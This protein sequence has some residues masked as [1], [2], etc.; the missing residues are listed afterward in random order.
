MKQESTLPTGEDIRDIT[1]L[2]ALKTH[3]TASGLRINVNDLDGLAKQ[4]GSSGTYLYR[5]L[6]ND[7]RTKSEKPLRDLEAQIM[8]LLH[9]TAT[10]EKPVTSSN[11]KLIS[12]DFIVGGVRKFL[13]H[14]RAHAYIG[15][16]YGPAGAGKTKACEIYAAQHSVNTLYLHLSMWKGGRHDVVKEIK[17]AAGIQ[18]VPKG[19]KVED[20]LVDRLRGSGMLLVID[21]AHRM[22]EAARRFLADFWEDSHLAIALIGNPEI[23][24]QFAKNDQHGSR[25]GIERDVTLDLAK[26]KSATARHLLDLHLPEAAEIKEVVKDAEETLENFGL[27]RTVEKRAALARTILLTPTNKVDDPALAWQMAKEQL[28]KVPKKAA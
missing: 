12:K 22:T 9:T 11:T 15:I 13:E 7:W 28:P 6:K 19:M 27:C 4:M 25:V 1:T 16:G 21:N 2:Q 26:T 8:A 20:Y 17:K 24:D 3:V 18:R 5:Y 14:V 23:Q 10:T